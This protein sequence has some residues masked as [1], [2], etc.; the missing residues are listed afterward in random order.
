MSDFITL[1]KDNKEAVAFIVAVSGGVGFFLN[2]FLARKKIKEDKKALRQQMITNNIAPM[3]QEWINDIRTKTTKFLSLLD[4]MALYKKSHTSENEEWK[5]KV[6]EIYE[7]NVLLVDE[8]Y[9]YL[10][11]A[12]PFS[13]DDKKEDLADDIRDKIKSIYEQIR[14]KD[15][16]SSN[17]YDSILNDI[18]SCLEVIKHLLKKEWEE[19]K[20]LKEIEE[21]VF[22]KKIKKLFKI[23]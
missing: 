12:L 14:S 3:R 9:F 11:I 2:Y 6:K 13:R 10:L 8:L 19:T 22:F 21:G 15:V 4:Y 5:L 7:R 18:Y 20:S 23:K 16:L 1:I 17:E